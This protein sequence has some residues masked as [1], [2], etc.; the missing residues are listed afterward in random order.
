MVTPSLLRL[1]VDGRIVRAGP[2]DAAALVAAG[3]AAPVCYS[4]DETWIDA[5]AVVSG[6]NPVEVRDL[7]ADGPAP[8]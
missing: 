3:V 5:L 1:H 6:T 8:S 4:M 7:T 2:A